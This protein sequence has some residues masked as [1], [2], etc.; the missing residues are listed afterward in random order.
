MYRFVQLA[1]KNDF[2]I[3]N[4]MMPPS[5]QRPVAIVVLPTYDE[6]ENIAAIINEIL[7]QQ[8]FIESFTLEVL[9]SDSHSK[10]GTLE[11]VQNISQKN[12][13]VHLIDVKERGIGIGLFNGFMHAINNLDASVLIEMDADFQ[14]NPADVPAL[15]AGIN[16][17]Y[18]V[19]IGS[20][21]LDE[22]QN[23]MPWLRRILSVGA[24]FMIRW[25][26]GLKNIKEITTSYRAFTKE[27]FLGID[28]NSV[29][30]ESSSFIPV[31][32]FLVKMVERGARVKEIPMTMHPRVCGY[33][34][35]QYGRYIS[36]ILR[37]SV[38]CYFDRKRS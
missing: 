33:S 23:R 29:P 25:L 32:V 14:H 34:K 35:M 11:I 30:W 31:P 19:V 13:R 12:L 37:F 4:L 20:R 18:D 2:G 3:V 38:S 1:A 36:D 17:G 24:N 22:S 10:D 21:F 9:V 27:S 16:E 5:K 6:K 28:H 15:L 7:A 26:L 8:D